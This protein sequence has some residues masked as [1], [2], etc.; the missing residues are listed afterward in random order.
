MSEPGTGTKATNTKQ[1]NNTRN[2]KELTAGD[3]MT[4]DEI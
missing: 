4:V 2:N 3:K 1:K